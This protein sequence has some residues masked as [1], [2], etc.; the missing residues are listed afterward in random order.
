MATLDDPILAYLHSHGIRVEPE[1]LEEMVKEAVGRLPRTL[2]RSDPRPDLTQAEAQALEQGGF[3]LAPTDLGT[4]DPLA[5]TA[6]EYAALLKASLAT[7]ELAARLG[8]DPSRIRQRLT[9]RPPTLYG[10]RLESGWVIPEFQLDAGR[11]I[12][13]LAEVVPQLDPDLHPVTVLRWF[14]TPNPDLVSDEHGD[15]AL[16][17]RDWLRLG[18]TAGPVAA[19]AGDL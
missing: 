18:L 14:T 19:L 1:A 10:I 2:Y 16:S 7:A 12:P 3:S 11:L 13:G 6:A 8:V 5:R 15:R 9:A 4:E 17:P